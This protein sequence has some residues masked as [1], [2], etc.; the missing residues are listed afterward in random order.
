MD[1]QRIVNNLRAISNMLDA[2]AE[3]Q[4]LDDSV[5][6]LGS[7]RIIELSAQS[8]ALSRVIAGIAE[9]IF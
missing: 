5:V 2:I 9:E 1:K 4:D 6:R 3:A 8:G 7:A